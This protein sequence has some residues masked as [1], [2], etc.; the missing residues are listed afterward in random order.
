[1]PS[2]ITPDQIHL[3]IPVMK[4]LTTSISIRKQPRLEFSMVIRSHLIHFIRALHFLATVTIPK[5]FYRAPRTRAL[6]RF[7]MKHCRFLLP[8]LLLIIL[9]IACFPCKG[10][11]PFRTRMKTLVSA[12]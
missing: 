3:S 9:K 5:S 6:L 1:M 12:L 8:H 4:C 10:S 2:S 11:H 7:T